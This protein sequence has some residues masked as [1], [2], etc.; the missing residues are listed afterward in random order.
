MSVV[1]FWFEFASTYSYPAALRIERV[2]KDAG[3]GISRFVS[4]G[5]QADLEAAELVEAL[6][7]HEATRLIAVYLEDFRD[8]RAFARAA[9]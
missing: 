5:N 2:A 9:A 8:G 3:L 4:I 1:Q 6:A 7:Q